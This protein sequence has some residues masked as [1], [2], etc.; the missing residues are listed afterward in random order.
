MNLSEVRVLVVHNDVSHSTLESEKDVL[1]EVAEVTKALTALGIAFI[2]APVGDPRD[3]APLLASHPDCDVVFNLYEPQNK[4]FRPGSLM[5]DSLPLAA[6]LFG[7]GCTGGTTLGLWLTLDKALT[8]RAV[9][10][11]GAPVPRDVEVSLS[12]TRAQ[13]DAAFSA[14]FGGDRATRLIVKPASSDGS[15]GI[16]WDKSVF[17]RGADPGAVWARAEEIRGTFGMAALVEEL[18]GDGELNVSVIEDPVPR[19]IAVAEID[20]SPMAAHLPHIV[21]YEAKWNPKSPMYTSVRRVPAAIP[22]HVARAAGEIALQAW[23][24]TYC[25]DYG[26]VDMRFDLHPD[27]TFQIW[28]LEVNVNPAISPDSGYSVA[29]EH[30]G[31]GF[32]GF[33]KKVVTN[34]FM[35]SKRF[36]QKSSQQQK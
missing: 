15:E 17:A 26:R 35:R 16:F 30:A 36:A 10:M 13:F 3:F 6:E 5:N 22:A 7:R 25:R 21:D 32:Q 4:D 1:D 33:I 28:V 14:E 8:K 20:F 34:A 29:C 12:M 9:R 19:V 31:I 18:I 27:G 24:A 11:A 2:V 23:K